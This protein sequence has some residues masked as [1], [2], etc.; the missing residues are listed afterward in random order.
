M[1]SL[2]PVS[3]HE[4]KVKDFK[5]IKDDVTSYIYSERKKD[6]KGVVKSNKH[7]WQSK[8]KY[9]SFENILIDT[10]LKEVV[11]YFSIKKIFKENVGLKITNLWIYINPKG[12]YN[13]RHVHPD[14][15]MSGVWWIKAPKNSGK[16]WF[17]NHQAFDRFA[18][19]ESYSEGFKESTS[20]YVDYYLE[21]ED[22]GMVVFPAFLSHN[23]GEN[24][25]NQERISVSFN[26]DLRP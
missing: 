2:F 26:I 24:E 9:A 5:I 8:S 25:S 19:F 22:G 18:E 7:G 12:A 3:I 1:R 21:P 11:D 16:L 17:N 14:A 20:T 15:H 10:V 4:I 13:Q 6:K 23:V